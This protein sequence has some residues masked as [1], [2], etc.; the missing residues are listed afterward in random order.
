[1]RFTAAMESKACRRNG[2]DAASLGTA[3]C[4]ICCFDGLLDREKQVTV[5]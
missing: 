1:M 3:I 2:W 5:V 4:H